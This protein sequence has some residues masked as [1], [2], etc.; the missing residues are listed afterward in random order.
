[1]KKLGNILLLHILLFVSSTYAQITYREAKGN[2]IDNILLLYKTM[3]ENDKKNLFL[4]P[5]IEMQK[6]AI[7]KSIG[8]KRLVVAVDDDKNKVIGFSKNYII[9]NTKELDETLQDELNIVKNNATFQQCL[10]Y[11]TYIVNKEQNCFKQFQP[12]EQSTDSL[13]VL[14]SC[15]KQKKSSIFIYTG[16]YYTHPEYRGLGINTQLCLYQLETIFTTLEKIIPQKKITHIALLYGQVLANTKHVGM[17]REFATCLQQ[18]SIQEQEF[19]LHHYL[20][21]ATKPEIKE[22]NGEH[23]V[24]FLPE[25]E[26]RGSIVIA[27]IP[28]KKEG[29]DDLLS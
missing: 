3:P 23:K 18:Q 1:M 5:T 24:V 14:N 25:N 8:K 13:I 2:D 15:L 10:G 22:I 27:K 6:N 19:T 11:K 17:I 28:N 4:F 26:G 21:K 16:G 9:D 29:I 12:I 20:F 7:L